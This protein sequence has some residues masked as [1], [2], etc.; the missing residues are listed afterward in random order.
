MYNKGQKAKHE[1]TFT[2]E[3]KRM[4]RKRKS[5]QTGCIS[6][7][8]GQYT[9]RF[10]MIDYETGKKIRKR[11]ILEGA[12][13]KKEARELAK[14][15]MERVNQHNN[16]FQFNEAAEKLKRIKKSA[17]TFRDFFTGRW[18][19]YMTT[20]KIADSTRYSYDSMTKNH[21][22][23]FFAERPL[24]EIAPSDITDFFN[25]LDE[26]SPK[27]ALNIYALLNTI[28]DVA[29][30]YDF[31]I[32]S[33]MRSRI[34]KPRVEKAEKPALPVATV[35]QI[36]NHMD[37]QHFPLFAV[38]SSTGMR[39]GE[40]LGVVWRDVDFSARVLYVKQSVWRGNVKKPK[41]Q[42]SIRKFRLHP[43]LVEQL[44]E[45]KAVSKFNAPDDFV[46]SREDGR[47]LDPDGLRETVLYPVMKKVGI[48]IC[49]R[50]YGFHIFR[51]TAGSI[52]YDITGKM[53]VVQK[54]LGHAQESTTS[55]IYVHTREDE[56]ADTA[57]LVA[58][59]IF[60]QMQAVQDF[61]NEFLN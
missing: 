40:C 51:H 12:I 3:V 5:Y 8:N 36:L 33:P 53:K 39:I 55:G 29:F 57:E 61:G 34:H 45:H 49:S 58:E 38:L 2:R 41:T 46:F 13:G 54:F 14:P 20:E 43:F 35:I 23:P 32:R 18:Q 52:G 11:E 59:E 60:S 4:V 24:K 19:T 28:F 48:E 1:P 6:P 27:F 21:I 22:M 25:Q 16:N 30:Q 9:V 10:W 15:I 50:A 44:Q 7:H 56:V 42:A 37:K 31:I 17:L 26:L 47:S